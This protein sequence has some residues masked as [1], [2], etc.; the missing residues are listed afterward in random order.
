LQSA[1]IAMQPGF[2]ASRCR[3]TM[4]AHGLWPHRRYIRR[5]SGGATRIGSA[6]DRI[7]LADHLLRC[8]DH[9]SARAVWRSVS[10]PGTVIAVVSSA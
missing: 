5:A 6:H 2:P 3:D 10:I 7:G 1:A 9:R 4:L 8:A